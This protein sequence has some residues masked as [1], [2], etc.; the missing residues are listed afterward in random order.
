[1]FDEYIHNYIFSGSLPENASTYVK[2]EADDELYEALKQGNFCYVLNSRQS[3]KSSLRLRTMSRLC[4]DG[5]ECASIDLSSIN[6]QSATQEN[7][8]ADLI[9][10]LIDSFVLDL[11]FENWWNKKQLNSPLMRFTNFIE[12]YLLVEIKENIVIFIDEIDSVLSLDFPTDDFF[13]FIR[14]CYNQRVDNPE[15]KRLTFC[16]LGVASPNNLIQDKQRTPFNIGKAISLGGFKLDEIEPLERGLR[17]K[18]SHSQAVIQEILN[19]TGGQ[20][21]LAQKLCQLM[22]DESEKEKPRNVEQV[23]KSRIIESWESQDEPE[24]LR[25]IRARILRNE[26]RAGYLL[27]LYQQIR[28]AELESAIQ[29]DNTIEQTE[30]LLSGLIAKRKGKLNVYNAIYKQVFNKSWVDSELNNLRPYSESFRFWLASDGKDES[31]LLWGKALVDAE[32]WAKDKNLSYQDKQFLAASKEK[33][34]QKKIAVEKRELQ[35]VTEKKDREAVERR[36]LV[37]SEANHKAKQ[38]IRNGIVVLVL[39]LFGAGTLGVL[40]AIE[41]KKALEVQ[42]NVETIQKLSG[43]AGDLRDENLTTAS[44][45]ALRKAGLSFRVKDLN[46]KQAMLMASIS[47][48]YQNLASK[49]FKYQEEAE[50]H[51]KKSLKYLN[52]NENNI[53]SPERLQIQVLVKANEGKL[54]ANKSTQQA[55]NAYKEAYQTLK[56]NPQETNPLKKNQILTTEDIESVHRGLIQLSSNQNQEVWNSLKQ[57]FYS[58]LKNYLSK[59]NW[60]KA[61]LTTERL[62]LF[63]ADREEKKYLDIPQIKNF[64]CEEFTKIDKLWVDSSIGKFGFSVQREMWELADNRL[65]VEESDW[66]KNDDKNYLRFATKVGRYNEDKKSYVSYIEY[67]QMVTGNPSKYAGGLP[68]LPGLPSWALQEDSLLPRK[69][70]QVNRSFLALRSANCSE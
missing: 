39:T 52:N 38:L 62:M 47:Q 17:E 32:E 8:Y 24:H 55:I 54:L 23:V 69:F 10:K 45:K 53:N 42:K 15:Y 13:A 67:M 12:K 36:N 56:N 11:D 63:I 3:G 16:L 60:R 51:Y 5:I 29:A 18:F 26:E 7:W 40:T 2:R 22:L 68:S 25:T 34:I 61:D 30:L 50:Y 48:A 27:E 1:M 20:P 19:W 57:H 21:F 58:K 35:L 44:D 6:I 46:L 9:T 28:L 70:L 65:G 49:D 59:K 66:N 64:S 4:A 41:G 31:R 43:L 14:S 37:L 33:E